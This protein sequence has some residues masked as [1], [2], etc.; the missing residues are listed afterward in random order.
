M[1]FGI[2]GKIIT[3]FVAVA[4]IAL[5]VGFTGLLQINRMAEAD[6]V[7]YEK[8]VKG[9]EHIEV[10]VEN[11]H[12]SRVYVYVMLLAAND[13]ELEDAYKIFN[14]YK[15]ASEKA[16]I[17]Y[18]GT[19]MTDAGKTTFKDFINS[20]NAYFAYI[21]NIYNKLKAGKKD[22]ALALFSDA[23]NIAG[24]T[25][26]KLNIMVNQKTTLG[27]QKN[28][29]NKSL[30]L[31]SNIIMIS[32]AVLGV[33]I[34]IIIGIILTRTILKVVN[35]IDNSS[36]QVATGAEQISSSSEELSQGVSE[37]AANVEE[38]SASIEEMTSTIQQNSDNANQTEKIAEKIAVDAKECGDAV[39]KTVRAMQEIAEKVFIIQEIARQTNLLSLN[40]SIEAA[41]AGEHGKGFAVVASEVQKLAERS[42]VSA[43]EIGQL[44]KVSV[45]IAIKAGD[46]LGKLVPDIQKTADLVGEINAASGEQASSINQ[47]NDAVQQLNSVVQQNAAN[48]EELAATAEE[49]S[50]QTFHMKEAIN[51]LKTGKRG[52]I[53]EQEEHFKNNNVK[54][55]LPNNYVEHKLM[56]HP[57]DK[58]LKKNPGIKDKKEK[59]GV[60]IDLKKIDS[61]DHDF[62]KY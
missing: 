52:E 9:L 17:E 2:G 13:K 56:I 21:L 35:T 39:N 29:E 49:L 33:I 51:F 40:A 8:I 18:E 5:V 61:E 36:S 3:A 54:K 47:I 22:E 19:L 48:S 15:S 26:E 1:K 4:L 53:I 31:M 43:V 45:D 37:Q 6:T 24:T 58:S 62:E 11:F 42:Q 20:K 27:N 25:Q 23:R 41:R 10:I 28:L 55:A 7:I 46:M 44:S 12:R 16:E 32:M 38:V 60:N 34:A 14:D 59:T 57:M 30:A 50:A